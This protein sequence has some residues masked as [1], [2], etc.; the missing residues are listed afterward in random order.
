MEGGGGAGL[1]FS[2]NETSPVIVPAVINGVPP[3]A[4]LPLSLGVRGGDERRWTA[5]AAFNPAA[6]AASQLFVKVAAADVGSEGA[7]L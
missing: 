2:D 6:A 4:R 7:C 3:L 5:G 1:K